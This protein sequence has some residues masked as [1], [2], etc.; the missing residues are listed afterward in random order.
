M[1]IIVI[2]N[3]FLWEPH[4]QIYFYWLYHI[5]KSLC[6]IVNCIGFNRWYYLLAAWVQGC[7]PRGEGAVGRTPPLILADQFTLYQP[8][9]KFYPPPQILRPFDIPG[10]RRFPIQSYH[11]IF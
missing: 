5:K 8:D 2:R 7:R 10:V 11:F 3:H 1:Y 9:G 6:H 4:M